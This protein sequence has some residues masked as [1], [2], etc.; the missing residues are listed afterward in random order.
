LLAPAGHLRH[1][2]VETMEAWLDQ[3]CINVTD[4]EATI[5]F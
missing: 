3:Y 2:D 1:A 5:G 4:I